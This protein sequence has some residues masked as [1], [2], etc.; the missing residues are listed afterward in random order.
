MLIFGSFYE[1]LLLT[2]LLE[3]VYVITLPCNKSNS[4]SVNVSEHHRTISRPHTA[5]TIHTKG[6]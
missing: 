5:S 2:K 6:K 1:Q 3:F 4:A